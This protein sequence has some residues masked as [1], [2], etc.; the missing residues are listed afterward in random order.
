MIAKLSNMVA[1][2][3]R[4]AAPAPTETVEVQV[5]H[6]CG[7]QGQNLAQQQAADHHQTQR[8]AQFRAGTGGQ[9]QRHGTEQR[10]QGGHQDRPETQQ[11]RLIDRR[12]RIHALIALCV[13][14]EV[15]HHDRVL[16]HDTDQQNDADDR[17]HAQVIAAQDQ[18]Q[19]GAHR[20]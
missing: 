13:E 2:G 6:R 19:Q 7:E 15:D 1:T 16:L 3:L 11:G 12:L 8:L 17:D 20:R 4:L 9:H 5:N 18:R 14:G 10:G